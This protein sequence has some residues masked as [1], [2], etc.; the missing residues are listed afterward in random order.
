[1]EATF[2]FMF[3][4]SVI[5]NVIEF[6]TNIGLL[7]LM[8]PKSTSRLGFGVV[9]VIA[10]KEVATRFDKDG[11]IKDQSDML[12]SFLRHGLTRDEAEADS[13]LQLY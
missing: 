7:S 8:A 4:F 3:P 2:P 9:L 11:K 10:Q 1:V 13:V 5:P 12:G 6:L